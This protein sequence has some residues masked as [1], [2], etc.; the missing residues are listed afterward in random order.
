MKNF[1]NKIGITTEG[2]FDESE[3]YVIDLESSDEYNKLYSKLAKSDY[4]EE[5]DESSK[6]DLDVSN[7]VYSSDDY[8][9]NLIADF[10]QDAYAVVVTEVEG[11]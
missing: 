8:I 6:I 1:L 10:K 7:I 5:D 11:E 2:Y 9:I 3:N 4:V